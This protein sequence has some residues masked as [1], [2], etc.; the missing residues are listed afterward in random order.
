MRIQDSTR[1]TRSLPDLA[2]YHI[3]LRSRL[4]TASELAETVVC[5][6]EPPS[7]HAFL[8][9]RRLFLE[10]SWELQ[11]YFDLEESDLL[12]ALRG[13]N[14]CGQVRDLAETIRLLRFGQQAILPLLSEM[15]EAT[16]GFEAPRDSCAAYAAFLDVLRAI[17][18]EVLQQFHLEN[19]EIFPNASALSEAS[20][21]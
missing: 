6:Q 20:V 14:G 7:C 4:L 8:S 1:L 13:R 12:P 3:G 21:N 2:Q 19:E 5:E 15:C 11:S 18:A 16:N 10:F 17:Q 9:L